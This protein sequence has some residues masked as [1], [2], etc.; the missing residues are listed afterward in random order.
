MPSSLPRQAIDVPRKKSDFLTCKKRSVVK[1]SF[2]F[3]LGFFLSI[4]VR[5]YAQNLTVQL[6]NAP[7]ETVF[8]VIEKQSSY[9]F[10]YGKSD[11][12]GALPVTINEKNSSLKTILDKCFTNQ[13]LF[14]T[15]KDKLIIVSAKR[16]SSSNSVRTSPVNNTT[17]D[18]GRLVFKGRITDSTETPLVGAVV[19]VKGT[20]VGTSTNVH[21]EFDLQNVYAGMHIIITYIG[22]ENFEMTVSTVNN[23]RYPIILKNSTSVL[24]ETIVQAYGI[25][26]KRFNVGSIATVNAATIEQQPVSNVLLALQ[27]QVPGL[28]V[29]SMNGVPG[30]NT[31]LQVRGQNTLRADPSIGWKPY[32]QPLL[33]VDGVPFAAQNNII[34]QL[35]SLALG[36]SVTGGI[37]QAS[38]IGAFGGIN[39]AD[40]ESISVLKDAEATS[41]YGTQGSNG[42]ILI[43]TK[44]G[45][46]GRTTLNVSANSGFNTAANQV[47]LM[48]TQQYL[49]FRKAAFAADGIT[50]SSSARSSAYAPDLTIFDQD[51]YTNWQNVIYGKTS[52][53]T[54][55]HAS[56][57]GGTGNNTFFLSGGFAKSNFNY[58]GDFADQRLTLHSAY[59][60][61]SLNNRLTIDAIFDYGYN[62][63]NSPSFGGGSRILNVP[64]L[65]DLLDPAGNLVWN[66]KG[67]NLSSQQ[68]YSY[69]KQPTV[70]NAYNLNASIRLGY[71]ISSALT[72]TLNIGSNRNAN[73]E[74]SER[75]SV[76]QGPTNFTRSANF[77][78]NNFQT[79]NIE[80]QFDYNRQFGNGI[81]SALLGGT[82]KKNDGIS[83]VV[84]GSGY[85]NDS[86]LGSIA[87]ASSVSAFDNYP[88]Y[89]YVGVFGRLKYVYNQKYIISFTG[90]RDGSSNFGPGRKFGNFGSVGGGWIFSEET[91]FRKKVPFI[92]YG[93][94]SASYGTTGS[95]GV[96]AYQYQPFWQSYSYLV[97]SQGAVPNIPQNLN[98]PDYSWATKRS[99][100][101]SIDLGISKD[102]VLLNATYYRN[103]EGNQLAGYPLPSQ[104][105]FSSVLENLSADLQNM[106]WEFSVN[107]RNI[108]K[109]HFTW[110]SNFNIAFNRNKLLSFP[111][112]STS[113]YR[114]QYI[115][116]QP[117][118][119][120]FGYKYKDVNPTTGLFEFYDRNG[121]VTS[122][123]RNSIASQGGDLVPIANREVKY[124][125]G[126]GN[127]FTFNRIGLSIFW[128]FS[129][130]MAP[131]YL[132]TV[133]SGNYPGIG[134]VNQPL[135]LLNSFWKAPGDNAPL[136]RL[137]SGFSA[138][139][140]AATAAAAFGQSSGVYVN[141]TYA[142]LKNVSLS[143]GMPDAWM[144]KIG[145]HDCRIFINGEN[146]LTFTN[147]KVGDPETFGNYTTFPIQRTIVAGI[148]LNY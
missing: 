117:T 61:K 23:I 137:L 30:A 107:S 46:V 139:S 29:N 110:N 62:R 36:G 94:L 55:I 50:P 120:V 116:G 58:P 9:S 77:A 143:Y 118:S 133:Y 6:T 148:N 135:E 127:T 47:K 109:K 75:P 21:G 35:S 114:T 27:G 40:I 38:G 32:D 4:N 34:S 54:D 69:L 104:T 44:K 105:G 98:N 76:A 42:V 95:D 78:Q 1:L 53:Y 12:K 100:N 7:L 142:R 39:P 16:N 88:I 17:A 138:N 8:N 11:L 102:R 134:L 140:K 10:I 74:H 13:P 92:S 56:V 45:K 125:G 33:I 132:A 99:L 67:V 101:I 119:I 126:L 111:N 129:S 124:M 85:S 83:M 48:N 81:F 19:Y 106:G 41:I 84:S 52:G 122:A 121:N 123:P 26:S 97:N 73:N 2:I 3:L 144:K 43:T 65:P 86:L 37:S 131:S 145:A 136:Q 18:T 14:F 68:F 128:Q 64:N 51:K 113:P 87:G 49:Q 28:A 24:D 71:K 89:K 82:Y 66:Y 90:R 5:A 72:F 20:K 22:F 147:Y 93:K 79:L 25:T 91:A 112:L 70:L 108:N 80:P 31:L 15:I 63:N 60:Y 96:A 59:Q 115:I 146:L 103:R 130:Q 57:S 141:D